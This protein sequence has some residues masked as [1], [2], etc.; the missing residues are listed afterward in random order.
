MVDNFSKIEQ[1]PDNDQFNDEGINLRELIGTLLENKGLIISITA[2]A[3]VIGIVKAIL[4]VPIY[5]ADAMLQV[6][7]TR[8]SM[9]SQDPF[10]G[11]GGG[12]YGY[13]PV[14]AEM[15][16]IKSRMVMGATVD[17]LNLE[18]VSYPKYFPVIGRAM[19]RSFAAQNLDKLASPWLNLSEY[20]WG[21][22]VIKVDTLDVPDSWIGRALTLIAGKEGYFEL[23]DS[24]G[25]VI[26]NG[27]VGKPVDKK[28]T[29]ENNSLRLF[30]SVLK[31][32]S[33]THFTL[34][35]QSHISAIWGLIGS[36]SVAEKGQGLGILSFTMNSASP[37]Y[38]MQ[39]LNEV[40]QIYVRM[41]VEKK[42]VEAQNTL[43]FL[44]KQLPTIKNQLE[45]ATDALNEYRL[46]KGSVDLGIETK[47]ILSGVVSVNAQITLLEQ[48]KDE[49]RGSF[50][51]FHPVIVSIDKQID[52]LKSQ[53]KKHNNKISEL[54]E[55][56]QIILRLSRDVEVNARLY[57]TMLNN[58]QTIKVSKAGTVGDVRVI[59]YAIMPSNP[60]KPIKRNIVMIAFFIGLLLALALVF[61]RKALHHGIEDPDIIEKQLNVPVYASVLHSE[62][63]LQLNRELKKNKTYFGPPLVLALEDVDDMAIE[64][65]RSLRTTL[66]FAFLEAKNNII[67]ITGPSPGVGKSFVSSNLAIV[68]ASSGK[69]ILLIDGDLR[70][71]L[72]N[73]V[74]GIS[75]ENGLSD[76]ISNVIKPSTAIH[77]IEPAKI[78]FIPTG[79]IPPNPSELLLH[80]NFG[81]L[82]EELGQKYDHIII[83]SPPILAVTDASI[84]GR[85]ASATL[86]VIRSGEHPLRELEQS[87]KRLKQNDI[88]I[89]GCIFNDVRAVS[90]G[91]GYGKY[92]YQYDY[93]K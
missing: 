66:H 50:T 78:D 10:S 12:G 65:L 45:I 24:A 18:V 37:A 77:R 55:T 48:K 79:A 38:A 86:M 35:R 87:V 43:E 70:K 63:Q 62:K 46:E 20:A 5:Q 64:S 26:V 8:S 16:V 75:R 74:F 17:R 31:A 71:G 14:G 41:D 21:G 23:V 67:M 15:V 84:I 60:I 49:L 42:S 56:Q 30:V 85:M 47:S 72:L 33:G 68:L 54:P 61:L 28:I 51:P 90:S 36:L 40:A 93:Q 22:E 92:F 19:A 88:E 34:L 80:E 53:L 4:Q 59:D 44:E 11:M 58:L 57:S 32:R 82:L 69:K 7:P 3:V 1:T 29:G 6:E 83:D 27:E 39:T 13:V 52:R 89:K 91:Y 2:I 25:N 9:M 76:L 81:L 73:K